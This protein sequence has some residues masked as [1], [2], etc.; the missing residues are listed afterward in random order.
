VQVARALV[1]GPIRWV[2]GTF[3]RDKD[4]ID[5]GRSD[6]LELLPGIIAGVMR[7]RKL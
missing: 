6:S 3:L 2:R 1:R 4:M 7:G 5:R